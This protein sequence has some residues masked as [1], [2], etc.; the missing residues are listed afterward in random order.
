MFKRARIAWEL[1]LKASMIKLLERY[2]IKSGVLIIDD[3]DSE[4]S[5]NTTEIAKV[6][7]IRDKK[8]AGFSADKILLFCY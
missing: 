4:R 1:L 2:G 6:H 8:H 3:T 7:K 5:T